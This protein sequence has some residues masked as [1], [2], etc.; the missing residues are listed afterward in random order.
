YA[1]FLYITLY[2][3]NVLGHSPMEAGL[4]LLPLTLLSLLV[5]PISGRLTA[6]V[7]LRIPLGLALLL[8]AV[9][10]VLMSPVDA[11]STWTVLLPGFL[12][13]GVATGM[14]NPPLASV[15]V[16]VVHPSRSGMASGI[17]NTFRQVGTATA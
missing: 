12:V 17:G 16:G 9:A 6:H 3:Q 7:P 5:A 10:L 11:D 15:T 8:I 1:M 2:L 13:A 14:V 4:Q